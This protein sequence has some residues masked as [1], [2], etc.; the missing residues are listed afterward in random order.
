[1]EEDRNR[2]LFSVDQKVSIV[3]LFFAMILYFYIIPIEVEEG[4]LSSVV[5]LQPSFMPKL[6][7]LCLA[8]LSILLFT[9]SSKRKKYN[10]E[11]QKRQSASLKRIVICVALLFS[12]AYS[13]EILG[14]T[15]STI[16]ALA[17]LLYFFGTKNKIELIIIP[18]GV[19]LVLYCFFRG[20]MEV[21]L[22]EGFI[23]T[24]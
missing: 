22:P 11:R 17:V 5:S 20:I 13:I 10:E 21:L 14:Y 1:M 24:G 12:Y 9:T 8:T 23:F 3:M 16:V 18:I 19:T 4:T 6:M 7:S 15:L 2:Q